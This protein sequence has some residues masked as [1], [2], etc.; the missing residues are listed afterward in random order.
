MNR[1]HDAMEHCGPPPELEERLRKNVLSAEPEPQARP[2]VYRPRG[3]FR[4]ALLAAV[5]I[6]ALTVSAG[7]A[8]LV[9]WDDIFADRFGP[10]AATTPMA[11]QAFQEVHV[12]SVCDDVTVTIREALVDGKSIYLILDYQLPDTVDPETAEMA[13]NSRENTQKDDIKLPAV[14]YYAT[15][16]ITWEELKASEQDT[17][18]T[19]DWADPLTR[20]LYGKSENTLNRLGRVNGS[21]GLGETGYDPATNTL[22]Y[23]CNIT[24][25]ADSLDFTAQPLTLLVTPPVLRV[26]GVDT[27]VTDH[28][29]ILTFQPS[30]V[31]QTLTGSYRHGGISARAVLSPLSIY[32][33]V[34]GGTT[35]RDTEA[36]VSDTSLLLRDGSILPA[37]DLIFGFTGSG[38]LDPGDLFLF[39]A[40]FTSQFQDLQ[41]VSQVTAVQVGDVTIPLE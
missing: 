2:A 29:A 30:A 32:V 18:A 27:A 21:S 33:E 28:P 40:D 3:F 37:A 1:Y 16:D 20:I 14:T 7:A 13:Y 41:D 26:N 5:L 15:D 35:Y 9:H 12:T 17:W 8:V 19:L 23:L 39:F 22:S 4:K 24:G 11:E 25:D 38:S 31:S 36:L 6:V 10:D 34:S